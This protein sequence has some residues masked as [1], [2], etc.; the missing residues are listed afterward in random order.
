MARTTDT[1]SPNITKRQ[2][3]R[4]QIGACSPFFLPG[5]QPISGPMRKRTGNF[6]FKLTTAGHLLGEYSN[7]NNPWARPECAYREDQVTASHRTTFIGEYISTWY[8][9]DEG[10]VRTKL[11]IEAKPAPADPTTQFT[12]TWSDLAD[13]VLFEGVAMLNDGIL[14]GHNCSLQ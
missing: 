5:I 3:E 6:Y 4:G 13:R 1:E 9:P 11:K 8:E 12:L 7:F 10:A 2:G 14:I